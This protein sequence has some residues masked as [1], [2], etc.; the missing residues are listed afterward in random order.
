MA[1]R[2]KHFNSAKH[3]RADI[4]RLRRMTDA[5]IE[6]TAPNELPVLPESFWKN[7]RVVVPSP[8]EAISFRVDADVLGWFRAAGPRYQ[9]R[10]NAVLRTYVDEMRR[11]SQRRRPRRAV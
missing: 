9:S 3:G 2:S 10:M 8:K 1:K 11:P 7:A 4:P 6:R 5:E